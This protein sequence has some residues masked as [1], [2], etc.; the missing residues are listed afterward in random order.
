[1]PKAGS[2]LAA[3]ALVVGLTV[4]LVGCGKAGGHAA[5]PSPALDTPS[6][7]ATASVTVGANWCD[8]K[9]P[10]HTAAHYTGQGPH[11]AVLIQL[12]DSSG[13]FTQRAFLDDFP[14]PWAPHVRNGGEDTQLVICTRPHRTRRT[15][16]RCAYGV[17]LHA[18]RRIDV[19]DT[20]YEVTVRAADTG[21]VVT[22]FE[23]KGDASAPYSCPFLMPEGADGVLRALT[24]TAIVA[25]LRPVLAGPAR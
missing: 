12:D 1:M 17:G 15:V 11:P 25:K 22:V 13:R 18:L 23:M 16:G 10:Y 4:G 9:D 14:S 2:P 19:V 20:S 6:P 3:V 8:G 21:R 24:R 7:T 5:W